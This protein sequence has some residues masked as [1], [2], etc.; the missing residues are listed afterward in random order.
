MTLA[1]AKA[2]TKGN[3]AEIPC[4]TFKLTVQQQAI[5]N[6]LLSWCFAKTT[7]TTKTLAGYAGTGKTT[8]IHALVSKLSRR[9]N[10]YV[11]APTHKAVKVLSQ[12]ITAADDFM[13][14]T[15]TSLSTIHSLLGIKPKRTLP[16]EPETFIQNRKPQ[17]QPKSLIIVDECSMIGVELYDLIVMAATNYSC[18]LLFTGD[19]KQLQ[20]INER[21]ISQTFNVP[22]TFQLTDVL[23]HD[24][25]ILDLATKVRTTPRGGIPRIVARQGD[26]SQVVTYSS[27]D[28]LTRSWLKQLADSPEDVIFLC[29]KN[30][31][32]REL[33]RMARQLLYGDDVPEFMAGDRLVM[34]EAYERGGQVVLSNNQ[35]I[36]VRDVEPVVVKPIESAEYQY[37]AWLLHLHN[38]E[39]IHVLASHEIDRFTKD[40]KALA[41]ELSSQ[42]KVSKVQYDKVLAYYKDKEHT[43]VLQA[44]AQVAGVKKRWAT[45]YF[46]LKYFFAQVDFGYA[47]TIHKSQGSTYKNVFI[48]ND[49]YS[50]PERLQ[51][52]YVAVT[53]ASHSV[54]HL[55]VDS[56]KKR[57]ISAAA[58]SQYMSS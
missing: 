48:H 13:Y 7:D 14:E 58:R 20:P 12:R 56:S 44:A 17:I 42:S 55:E 51:L 50:S 2:E 4:L 49:Y 43:N 47:V 46:P 11:T 31:T 3:G 5:L 23:R 39:P 22:D 10:I 34:I 45:E 6:E 54:H 41:S 18:K 36:M 1:A 35:D 21:S 25:A 16:H 33:N 40:H 29:W 57:T 15:V 26:S 27:L 38:A 19:P 9:L 37:D 8:I 53:R 24:G 28:F 52:L 32:R 30:K